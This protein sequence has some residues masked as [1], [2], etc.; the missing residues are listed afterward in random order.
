MTN[1]R[2]LGHIANNEAGKLEG[3]K[4]LGMFPFYLK[5][6]RNDVMIDC[7][8]IKDKIQDIKGSD[9]T[10]MNDVFD[11][12]FMK[13]IQPLV[14]EYVT[15]GLINKSIIGRIFKPFIKAKVKSCSNKQ[16]HNLYAVIQKLSDY[17]FFLDILNHLNQKDH[18][19]LKEEEV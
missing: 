19:I 9:E 6:L 11:S 2:K 13:Q 10:T 18:V 7:L 15:I 8:I 1:T 14:Y 5:H 4:V 12:L 3:F 16:L 17:A